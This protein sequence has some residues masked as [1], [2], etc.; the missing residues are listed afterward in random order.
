[1]ADFNPAQ[2]EAVINKIK[3]AISS[4]E[5]KL[6]ELAAKAN[7]VLGSWYMDFVPASVKNALK[8]AVNELIHI[9]ETVLHDAEQALKGVA[10]PI[11]LFEYAY[12][13]Q[14]IDGIATGINGSLSVANVTPKG[15]SGK[16]A[17]AYSA[18][19]SPQAYAAN[20]I[21]TISNNASFSLEACAAAG[22]AFYL[23]VGVIVVLFLATLIS[24]IAIIGTG[25]FSAPGL[26]MLVGDC[27]VTQG[28]FI[29]AAATLTGL[30]GT[31]LSQMVALHG[32]A[33]N[34]S[35]FPN[36]RWPVAT[37]G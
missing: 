20:Q 4:I 21:G 13:L 3:S 35:Y 23:S 28:M 2:Y 16:A 32:Q 29:A 15:W 14:D 37:T 17:T 24:S 26:A 27:S 5:Q 25:V 1:M 7:Q 12:K 30:L 8:W 19:I 34:G 9:G 22:L 36:G 6:P 10:M 31:Q 18:V 11:Y 33:V